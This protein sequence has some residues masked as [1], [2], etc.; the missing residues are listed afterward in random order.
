MPP[1]RTPVFLL[2]GFLGAG[3]TTLLKAML[4]HPELA[5]SALLINEIGQIA[6]DHEIVGT[7]GSAAVVLGGGCICCS[8]RSDVGHTLRDLSIR[9]ASGSIPSFDRVMI[10]TTGLA[11]PAP[12]VSAIVADPWIARRYELRAILTLADAINFAQTLDRHGQ[13]IRQISLADRIILTKTDLIDNPIAI[14]GV[15]KKIRALNPGAPVAIANGGEIEP[16][17]LLT[18]SLDRSSERLQ[19]WLTAEPAS[20]HDESHVGCASVRLTQPVHWPDIAGALDR[21]FAVH[22]RTILRIKALLHVHGTDRPVVVHGV[23]GTFHPPALLDQWLDGVHESRVVFITHGVSAASVA[24][25]F[26]TAVSGAASA[27]FLS[28]RQNA[29]FQGHV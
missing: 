29:E 3:K 26:T 18:P 11:D 4:R 23:Q 7:S 27:A 2:T 1:E 21:L 25:E 28:H 14:E 17:F 13:A 19:S 5:R 16:A 22:G 6:L 24:A 8:L 12:I 15:L 10:E 20:A 9:V